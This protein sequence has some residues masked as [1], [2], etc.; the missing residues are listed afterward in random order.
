MKLLFEV[1]EYEDMKGLPFDLMTYFDSRLYVYILDNGKKREILN[2]TFHNSTLLDL[3]DHLITLSKGKTKQVDLETAENAM[4]YT[5]KKPQ[6]L[7]FIDCFSRYDQNKQRILECSFDDFLRAFTLEYQRYT[8][9][10][11]KKDENA[12]EDETFI[13]MVNQLKLLKELYAVS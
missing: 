3:G 8:N 7:L 2:S 10:L 11:M 1:E 5:F 6:N 13:M 4:K 9:D 12:Y